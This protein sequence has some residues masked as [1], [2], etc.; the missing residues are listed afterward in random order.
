MRLERVTV[1]GNVAEDN[2]FTDCRTGP[3]GG[4]L[5]NGP[6]DD[7]TLGRFSLEDST[8]AYNSDAGG[9]APD[10]AGVFVDGGSHTVRFRYRPT[11]PVA[12]L[13]VTGLAAAA[14]FAVLMAALRR[15]RRTN[16][17]VRAVGDDQT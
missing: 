17:G 11:A 7:G 6:G 10:C 13:A 1:G 12:G 3:A 14:A 2:S 4:G 5:L 15:R 16:S 9:Q 8:I